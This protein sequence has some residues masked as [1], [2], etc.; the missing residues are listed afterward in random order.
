V[1]APRVRIVVPCFNEAARLPVSEFARA[2]ETTA[3]EFCFVDD[4]STEGTP[5][6]LV[7]LGEAHADLGSA[8]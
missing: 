3:F 5:A 2:I 8:S 4:G 1:P 7:R 6:I